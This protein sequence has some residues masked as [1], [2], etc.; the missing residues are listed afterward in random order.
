MDYLGC[1]AA[2]SLSY[3]L[4]KMFALNTIPAIKEDILAL[5]KD[6]NPL[7]LLLKMKTL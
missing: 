4:K 7:K 6:I 1:L 2:D 5:Q 3:G